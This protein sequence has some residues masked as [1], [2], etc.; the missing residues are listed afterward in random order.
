MSRITPIARVTIADQSP[1]FEIRSV[2]EYQLAA[3]MTK[4]SSGNPKVRRAKAAVIATNSSRTTN[5]K[6][7]PR[8]L[9]ES[10][11]G[12]QPN[13]SKSAPTKTTNAPT[14][15]RAKTPAVTKCRRLRNA[16]AEKLIATKMSKA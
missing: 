3:A 10:T 12:S 16:K 8:K 7:K 6:W 4:T 14:E 5:Q 15:L 9:S 13:Q 2:A 11:C 1:P